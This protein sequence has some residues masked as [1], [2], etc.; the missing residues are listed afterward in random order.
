MTDFSDAE[1]SVIESVFPQCK[2]YLCEFHREQSWERW[3]KKTKSMDSHLRMEKFSLKC[4][5]SVLVWAAA[6]ASD[7]LPVDYHHQ[8][9]V[10]NLKKMAGKSASKRLALNANIKLWPLSPQ[11]STLPWCTNLEHSRQV[12]D[13]T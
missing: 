10:D 7:S 8:Q 5:A 11:V 9:A 3:I 12:T 2:V 4:S 6:P 13:G 1:I